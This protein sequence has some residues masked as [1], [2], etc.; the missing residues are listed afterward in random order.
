MRTISVAVVMMI[1]LQLSVCSQSEQVNARKDH[2]VDERY[3]LA[4]SYIR[5]SPEVNRA[6][7]LM[8]LDTNVDAVYAVS[9]TI[10][11]PNVSSFGDDIVRMKYGLTG[12]LGDKAA[13]R[14]HAHEEI[15]L[16][17]ARVKAFEPFSVP[18]MQDL[19]VYEGANLS[20]SF[21]GIYT[22]IVPEREVLLAKIQPVYSA[23]QAEYLKE[24]GAATQTRL[25]FMFVCTSAAIDTVFSAITQ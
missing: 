23:S 25:L 12:N 4:L 9:S 16:N 3:K 22:D 6:R 21:S 8:Y 15:A 11:A 19:G 17:N 1:S 10:I 5:E 14:A 24:L 13:F 7:P 18:G 20:V 2:A